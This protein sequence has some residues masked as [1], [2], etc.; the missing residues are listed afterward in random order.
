MGY[1]YLIGEENNEGAYKIGST[2]AKDVNKRLKQLQTGN[3]SPLNL[4][5]AYETEHPFRLE[6]MLHNHFKCS[7]LIGEWFE[8]SETDIGQFKALC[9]KYE[10]DIQALQVNPFFVKDKKKIEQIKEFDPLL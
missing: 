1:V 10:S 3:S 6:Q 2:R 4:V 8:L 7:N 9:D 5:H